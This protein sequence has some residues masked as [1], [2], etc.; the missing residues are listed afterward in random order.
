MTSIFV[1]GQAEILTA[2]PYLKIIVS[3]VLGVVDVDV[4]EGDGL[5][6]LDELDEL[7]GLDELDELG[8]PDEL[9]ELDELW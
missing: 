3:D 2:S 6:E 1:P 5:Y 9:G 7:D 8:E 4:L